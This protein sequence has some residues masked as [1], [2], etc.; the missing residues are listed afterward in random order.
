MKIPLSI[1]MTALVCVL[2]ISIR[3]THDLAGGSEIGN[4]ATI[5]GNAVYSNTGLPASNAIVR[6]RTKDFNASDGSVPLNGRGNRYCNTTTDDSGNFVIKGID[7]GSYCIEINDDSSKHGGKSSAAAV[8]CTVSAK[9][10]LV[11]VSTVVNLKKTGSITGSYLSLPDS[12][13]TIGVLGI[14][15]SGIINSALKSFSIPDLPEGAYML[16]AAS[17]SDCYVPESNGPVIVQSNEISTLNSLDFVP[18]SAWSASH[19]LTLN[20]TASGANVSGNVYGF[21]LLIRL[22]SGNFDFSKAKEDGSDIRFTKSNGTPLPYEI[23]H[24]DVESKT[25]EIWVKMDTVYGDNSTQSL[26][27]YWGNAN[28]FDNS[29]GAAVFDTANGFQG[30]WH[31]NESGNTIAKDATG[32]HYNGTP[33][34][35]AP[36]SSPGM[37][38]SGRS[39]NGSSNYIQMK[40]TATGKLNF[41]ED[42]TYTISAW[43]YADTLDIGYHMVAGKNNEQ[44]FLGLKR[45]RPDT[46]M[47]WEFVE[48][49]NKAGWQITQDFPSAKVWTYLVGVRKGTTQYLYINENLVDSTIEISRSDTSRYTGDD[50]TVGRFLSVPAYVYEGLCA[51]SG[52][53]DEV[54]VSSVERGTDW[55]KLCYMNQKEQNALV[56]W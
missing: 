30:V 51:F 23:E 50:F 49:H 3:C 52:K 8:F 27:M 34:D 40:G 31:L 18:M 35:T 45:S 26:L 17:G 46:T 32:N 19:R 11:S 53:I 2:G 48:Y 38:G 20:T 55:V 12:S 56:E 5:V 6:L 29:N 1:I 44:Y 10:S 47:R 33:S 39:F 7:S 24:W 22:S 13:A 4:P 54:R 41:P 14:D 9:D 36:T 37:I 15:R 43:V 42:G 16:Y 28:A 21:P 25:A